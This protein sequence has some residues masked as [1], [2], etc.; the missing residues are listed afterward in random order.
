MGARLT[1]VLFYKLSIIGG[2]RY[3]MYHEYRNRARVLCMCFIETQERTGC[4]SKQL[5]A[6][7]GK[8]KKAILVF[9][10]PPFN[11]TIMLSSACMQLHFSCNDNQYFLTH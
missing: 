11:V 2:L 7:K 6:T 8:W 4:L 10:A 1:V 3:S 9:D 5:R